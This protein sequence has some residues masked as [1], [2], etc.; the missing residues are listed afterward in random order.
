MKKNAILF[1]ILILLILLLFFMIAQI[2]KK[3]I[4]ENMQETLVNI[5][6]N[7]NNSQDNETTPEE[8]E[9]ILKGNLGEINRIFKD[10]SIT[11]TG[12]T[13]LLINR[14]NI[15]FPYN[16]WFVIEKKVN[17]SWKLLKFKEDVGID[18]L[19]RFIKPNSS[20]ELKLDWTKTYGKLKKRRI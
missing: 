14:T 10:G 6:N 19:G 20:V 3:N 2:N 13:I 15:K 9:K 8:Q 17:N 18:A 5:E 7:I 12:A 11:N 1:I 16:Y 4:N